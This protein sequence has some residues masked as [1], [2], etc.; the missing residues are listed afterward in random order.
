LPKSGGVVFTI[1]TYFVPVS[2]LC[3]E[4]GVPARLASAIRSWGDD[5]AQY[6]GRERYQ[7]ALLAWLDE[8]AERQRAEGLVGEDEEKKETAYPF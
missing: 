3:E 1:R 4:P 7:E 6:K 5:V 2:K 8:V